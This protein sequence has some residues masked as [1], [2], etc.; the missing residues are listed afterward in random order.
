MNKAL[1]LLNIE[2]LQQIKSNENSIAVGFQQ[3]VCHYFAIID[4]WLF[5]N[6]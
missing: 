4:C 5:P 6:Y 2:T 3:E 1:I